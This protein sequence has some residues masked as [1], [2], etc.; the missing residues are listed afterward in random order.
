MLRV[1]LHLG[2]DPLFDRGSSEIAY[3]IR[4]MT[5]SRAGFVVPD[6]C[7]AWIDLHLPP[8]RSPAEMEAAIEERAAS[9]RALRSPT[10]TCEVEFNF[11]AGGYDLGTENE[12]LAS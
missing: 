7:E 5:S 11:A 1:L 9:R 10:S 3:S 6:R 2:R 8:Q 4:E 12:S